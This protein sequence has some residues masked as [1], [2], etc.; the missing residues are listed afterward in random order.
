MKKIIQSAGAF[1]FIAIFMCFDSSV[2]AQGVGINTTGNDPDPSALLDLNGSPANDKGLLVPRLTTAEMNDIVAPATGLIIYNT[3][4]NGL[5]YF[6]GNA[7][8]ALG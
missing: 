1:S 8:I 6:N 5:N 2:H 7:W 3:D 4:C